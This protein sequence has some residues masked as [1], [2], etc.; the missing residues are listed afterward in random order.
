VLPLIDQ[1]RMDLVL[2]CQLGRGLRPT[3]RLDGNLGIE[4]G[5]V[6]I[7]LC[8]H[9]FSLLLRPVSTYRQSLR[10][11]NASSCAVAPCHER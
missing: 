3:D 5:T 7:S 1:R 4:Y 10:E 6:T 8:G 2:A 9:G 11:T